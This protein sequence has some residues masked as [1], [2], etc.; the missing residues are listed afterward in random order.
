MINIA[1]QLTIYSKLAKC[2]TRGSHFTVK[3]LRVYICKKIF[4]SSNMMSPSAALWAEINIFPPIGGQD[5]PCAWLGILFET[6]T[7]TYNMFSTIWGHICADFSDFCLVHRER[8]SPAYFWL[9]F[10]PVTILEE[11]VQTWQNLVTRPKYPPISRDRCSNTPV[12]LRFLWYRR[13]SLL[14]PHFFP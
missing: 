5:V 11:R 10:T 3:V 12:A 14:H 4:K 8:G 1:K 9:L 6:P 7:P 2:L 13:L